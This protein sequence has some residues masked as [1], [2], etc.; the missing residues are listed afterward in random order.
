M[1]IEIKPTSS[2][3]VDIPRSVLK[4]PKG[5]QGPIGPQGPQGDPGAVKLQIV[6]ALPEIGQ[7]D[8]IYLVQKGKPEEH[9][10]YEE[11]IYTNGDWEHIGDTSVDLSDYYNKEETDKKLLVKQDKL[12]AGDNIEIIDNVISNKIYTIDINDIPIFGGKDEKMLNM[13]SEL[14]Q[15]IITGK[16]FDFEL[17]NSKAKTQMSLIEINRNSSGDEYLFTQNYFDSFS[18]GDGS[19]GTSYFMLKLY[20]IKVTIKDDVAIGYSSDDKQLRLITSG[21]FLGTNNTSKYTPT[22]DYN[23]ATKKYVDDSVKT[24]YTDLNNKPQIQHKELEISEGTTLSQVTKNITLE[25]IKSLIDLG[26]YQ[27]IPF[28]MS[29]YTSSNKLN[30]H[31]DLPDGLYVVTS[32]GTIDVISDSWDLKVGSRIFKNGDY[33]SLLTDVGDMFYYYDNST[34]TYIGGFYVNSSDMDSTIQSYLLAYVPKPK[35]KKMS[36]TSFVTKLEDNNIY[37]VIPTNGVTK[38]SMTYNDASILPTKT[39]NCHIT[40]KTS[41]TNIETTEPTISTKFIGIDCENGA[42]TPKVGMI[43]DMEIVWNGID[44]VA[45]VAG[46]AW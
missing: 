36:T 24:N 20:C 9:N 46:Y 25:G 13:F 7:S 18:K 33:L 39:F 11:Y 16:A 15:K 3:D 40:L 8:T 19:Y 17:L 26:I 10:L 21:T 1:E 30:P 29:S 4:G 12:T 22:S 34:N 45:N 41:K 44:M 31:T 35:V 42:F 43:Y 2:I 23:P 37:R 28:D 14:H 38:F 6:D 27:F 5:D 32:G